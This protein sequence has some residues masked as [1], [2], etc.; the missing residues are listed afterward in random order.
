MPVSDAFPAAATALAAQSTSF[1]WLDA[2][3]QA[4]SGMS[5]LIVPSFDEQRLTWNARTGTLHTGEAEGDG[6]FV[7]VFGALRAHWQP[8]QSTGIEA[9]F[10]GGWV[11]WF[12]YECAIASLGVALPTEDVRYPD[13]AWF[14]A[15]A[16]ASLDHATGIVSVDGDDADARARLTAALDTQ[17]AERTMA[18]AV[19]AT[20]RDTP[21]HYAE[22]I[23]LAQ[24]LIADGEAYQLC[25][26]S[27]V[28]GPESL[29]AVELYHRLR[30][31][32]PSHHGSLIRI[33]DTA[34][35]SI[36]PE[37]FLELS[38][39]GRLRS[40]PIKGTRRRGTVAAEDRALAAE[41]V[42]SEKERAE[43][44]MIVDLMRNDLGRVAVTGSVRVPELLQVESYAPVHQLVSTVEA[45]LAPDRHPLD[46]V[47]AAFPAGSMTGAPKHRA[48]TRLAELESGPRGLYSGAHGYLS[49]DGS[50]DLAMTIR[51]VVVRPDGW[52]IGAGGGITALS[53]PEHEVAEAHLKA[54]ALLRAL[55][56]ESAD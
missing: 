20:W 44:I 52:S 29:D 13:A 39:S 49:D 33:G 48:V 24:R 21:H 53:V 16:W 54:R 2:G 4:V 15:A 10:R 50:I 46:A 18:G 27:R 6:S 51:T 38:P 11:G 25:F 37:Q 35:A 55:G 5:Y 47:V 26:T 56:A 14:R 41:L 34:L 19:S 23:S 17:P 30:A 22:Q 32:A 9:R 31:V 28:Y 42:A 8:G 40:K 1:A 36:S 12:G 3:P 43:N 45:Q 7:D